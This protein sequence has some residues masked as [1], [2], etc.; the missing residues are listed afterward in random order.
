[1]ALAGVGVWASVG[2]P[3]AGRGL[4]GPGW[5]TQGAAGLGA[6]V[7]LSES[8]LLFQA[9]LCLSR[10]LPSSVCGGKAKP[11]WGLEVARSCWVLLRGAEAPGVV[12]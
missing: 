2:L 6:Q 11:W 9:W 10:G 1:M 5:C 4:G 12:W 8:L 7:A 3:P